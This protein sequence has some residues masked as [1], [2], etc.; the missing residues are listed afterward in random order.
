MKNW[1][2]WCLSALLIVSANVMAQPND[3]ELSDPKPGDQTCWN[4]VKKNTLGWGSI[5]VRYSRSQVP[6]TRGGVMTLNAWR[7]E[8]VSAQAVLTAAQDLNRVTVNVSDLKSGRNI[9]PASA[10]RK[11]FVRYV[12]TDW[13]NNKADSFLLPDRLDPALSLRVEAHTARPLWFDVRVPAETVPG[14][15]KG[16]VTVIADGQKLTLPLAVKVSKHTLPAPSQ[17]SYHLDLWQNPYAVARYYQVPLWSQQHFDLMRPLMTQLAEMGQKVITASIIQHPWNSQTYDPFES[18]IAK[19]KQIDGTW[20]YDYTVFDRW[21]EFMMSCG[22]TEQIDCY[23]LVPWH[24][25]FDY[26]DCATNSTKIV[27]CKPD[28][29]EYHDFI[30]PFLWDFAKHLKEKGWFDRTCIAMDERPVAQM[31]AAYAI[32]KEADPGY[33]IAGAANYSVESKAAQ[34]VYDM[35]VAHDYDIISGEALQK[36]KDAGLK[37]TFYTC[38]GPDRPNTFTFSDPAESS[39]LAWHAAAL[40][41]DG[42][43]RWAYN[44]WTAQPNQDSRF[45]TWPSGDCFIA[46]PGG[47]SIRL[48]RMVEGIQAYEKI[49]ILQRAAT[50]AQKKLLDD[51]LQG[52]AA[53]QYSDDIDA[54]ALIQKAQKLLQSF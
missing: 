8:R 38:C 37:L 7:G 33:R 3:A 15:Y 50:P 23:T 42:Y 1:R 54:A 35:S 52:F 22:I 26:Y 24:Y 47:S 17:W 49:R 41:Y 39:Y 10:I 46:Y 27:A 28:Q 45:I 18:M 14:T 6:Q 12:M 16:I 5:D 36:R 20:K 51:M 40:R 4:A 21:I 19:M 25:Q 11:Y 34:K 48:E 44:S 13:H 53:N 32:V 9:I 31:D 30:L 29:K 43:L 2:N